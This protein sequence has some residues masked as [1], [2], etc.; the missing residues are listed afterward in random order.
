MM[1]EIQLLG[2]TLLRAD[3]MFRAIPVAR[4]P[5]LTLEC[6]FCGNTFR[7]VNGKSYTIDICDEC[8]ILGKRQRLNGI[9]KKGATWEQIKALMAGNAKCWFCDLPVTFDE[10]HCDHDHRCCPKQ[11]GCENC[12]RGFTHAYCNWLLGNLEGMISR[13]GISGVLHG[14]GHL[15]ERG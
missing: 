9:R 1:Q 13:I 10:A 3:Q 12:F 15:I 2:R 14:I 5:W 4:V 6:E 8:W 11:A 7:P